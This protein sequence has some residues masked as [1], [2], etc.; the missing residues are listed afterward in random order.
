MRDDVHELVHLPK[1]SALLVYMKGA[2][3][4]TWYGSWPVL[5]DL[6][7]SNWDG[8]DVPIITTLTSFSGHSRDQEYISFAA[9]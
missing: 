2:S 1:S 4:L 3:E 5:S 7:G 6:G 8:W 9:C